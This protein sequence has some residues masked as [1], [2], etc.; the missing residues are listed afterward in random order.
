[1]QRWIWRNIS[2]E[3]P[4]EW[5][6]LL[7]SK[8]RKAGSLTF[9]D[10]K[11][12]RLQLAW[13]ELSGQPDIPRMARD[14]ASQL[15]A[16][17]AQSRPQAERVAG[18]WAIGHRSEG[19][20][21]TR[22]VR[23]FIEQNLLVEAIAPPTPLARDGRISEEVLQSVNLETHH[24]DGLDEWSAFG[25]LW[26]APG[27]WELTSAQVQPAS[28]TLEFAPEKEKGMY[29]RVTRRGMVRH[30]LKG[31]VAEWLKLQ[32][33]S[34]AERVVEATLESEGVKRWSVSGQ[35]KPS[36]WGQGAQGWRKFSALAWICPGDG[37]LFCHQR[38]EGMK[39]APPEGSLWSWARSPVKEFAYV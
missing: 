29:D 20:S 7:F 4:K 12:Y 28:V 26:Q 22:Y 32:I 1:M 38:M 2:L 34:N 14:Y 10:R 18:W 3:L 33:P 37:R 39:E 15:L 23:F 31:S 30:W 21:S 27:C 16:K 24:M 13:R 35:V 6:L 8:K 17:D 19:M 25:M 36:S 5:E 9:A 11:K